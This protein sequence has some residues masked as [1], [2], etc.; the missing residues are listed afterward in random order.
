MPSR[1]DLLGVI[2]T[3]A[4]ASLATWV[5]V[6][7]DPPV[8][9]DVDVSASDLELPENVSLDDSTV[10]APEP[11][12]QL[13]DVPPLLI[14]RVNELRTNQRGL[15]ALETSSCV[16]EH[17]QA[18]ADDM[19]ATGYVG[20]TAPDGTT[21]VERYAECGSFGGENIAKTYLN[22]RV[23]TVNGAI[24]IETAEELADAVMTQWLNS[25]GHRERGIYGDWS[26]IN[27]GLAR[28]GDALYAVMGFSQ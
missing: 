18:H 14:T 3:G 19:A 23:D 16:K 25:T 15:P 10:A 1:R 17:A 6:G 28:S 26:V 7:D 9:V 22:R 13:S 27:I 21:Q 20:H 2:T 4:T 5:V 24:V 12:I 11:E 8:S